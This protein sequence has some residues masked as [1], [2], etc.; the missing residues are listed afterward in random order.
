MVKVVHAGKG[1]RRLWWR[2]KLIYV[3]YEMQNLTGAPEKKNKLRPG[4]SL[5][6]EEKEKW[7]GR[8]DDKHNWAQ[9]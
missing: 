5:R 7:G 6:R 2:E 8:E 3:A 1:K 9:I 4:S